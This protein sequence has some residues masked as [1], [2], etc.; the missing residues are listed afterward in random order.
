LRLALRPRG[1][2]KNSRERSGTPQREYG[3]RSCDAWLAGPIVEK[4]GGEPFTDSAL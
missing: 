2:E 3:P 1:A 4:K